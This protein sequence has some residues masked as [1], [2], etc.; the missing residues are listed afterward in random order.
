MAYAMFLNDV[1]GGEYSTIAPRK[2]KQ[3]VANFAPQFNNCY[4]HD[5][6]EFC[7]FLM[8]GLHEDLNRV[9]EKP[10]V[11]DMEGAGLRD[12]VVAMETWKRHL[13]RHD[14]VV[15]DDCQGM[16]RSHLTC[17]D[18]GHESLK[19]D[20]YST[21]S[22]PVLDSEGPL[23]DCLK[24]FTSM[25]QLDEENAWFCSKCKKHV[26]AK[27][28]ITLWST[29]DIL[30]LHLKRFK[31]NTC[32]KNGRLLRSKVEHK[33]NFPVDGLDMSPFMVGPVD[34]DAPPVYTLFGVSE[35][36]GKTANSGHYTATV[37]NSADGKWY[38]FNDSHVGI[39][40]S[41]ASITGGAYVLFYQRSKGKSRWGGMENVIKAHENGT[42][43]E[44][45]SV[46]YM[47]GFQEVVYKSKKKGK[48]A[49]TW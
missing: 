48:K 27:K 14:S 9:I 37:R 33:V 18:C 39:T 6:Q 34:K 44:D 46:M 24:Q 2:L 40:S 23:S 12:E 42:S 47:D 22:L 29:P 26:C 20:V 17:P 31:F 45:D 35:H 41:D 4:Q 5:S 16:H 11:E 25:E 43:Q 19:F 15:V 7:S 38:R 32:N 21:I 36:Q 13:L 30:I 28:L 10:Y 1:W 3:T 49:E 8:D